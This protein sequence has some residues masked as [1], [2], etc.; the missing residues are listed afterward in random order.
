MGQKILP[1]AKL[2]VVPNDDWTLIAQA[3]AAYSHNKEYQGVLHRLNKQLG[4]AD[5]T[6]T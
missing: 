4:S 6:K 2:L 5:R 1:T 3:L